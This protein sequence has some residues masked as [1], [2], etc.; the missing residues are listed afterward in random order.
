[1]QLILAKILTRFKRISELDL[2]LVDS[3]EVKQ[4]TDTALQAD[5]ISLDHLKINMSY[6][7]TYMI[8][9]FAP[10]IKQVDLFNGR[11]LMKPS[12]C[13][14]MFEML[15]SCCNLRTLKIVSPG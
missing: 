5:L 6:S 12:D 8:E 1:M 4:F 14:Q 7:P 11:W 2:W 13:D 9:K 3:E 10:L 15:P